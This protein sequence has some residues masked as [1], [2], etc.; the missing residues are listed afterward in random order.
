MEKFKVYAVIEKAK[1]GKKEKILFLSNFQSEI[2]NYILFWRANKRK[3]MYHAEIE[4]LDW[5]HCK[6]KVDYNDSIIQ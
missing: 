5:R 6:S 4:I 2:T 3:K 1:E